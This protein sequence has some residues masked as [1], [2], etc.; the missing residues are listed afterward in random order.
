MVPKP[1]AIPPKLIIGYLPMSTSNGRLE[2]P[3]I[4][5]E[6]AVFWHGKAVAPFTEVQCALFEGKKTAWNSSRLSGPLL[7]HR[8]FTATAPDSRKRLYL[9]DDREELIDVL[10]DPDMSLASGPPD[11]Q[12][13]ESPSA[14]SP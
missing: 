1:K 4:K 11:L 6:A 12:L 8:I 10:P 2:L 9:G 3:V 5:I 7:R 13:L 14:P